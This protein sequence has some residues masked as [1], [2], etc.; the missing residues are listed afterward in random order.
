MLECVD[1]E[2]YVDLVGCF[3]DFGVWVYYVDFFV[4]FFVVYVDF[5]DWFYCEKVVFFDCDFD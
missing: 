4:G 2:W 3:V 1:V 5:V